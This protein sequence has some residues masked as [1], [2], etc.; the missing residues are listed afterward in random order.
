[1]AEAEKCQNRR[2]L[3]QTPSQDCQ[4]GNNFSLS[5][6]STTPNEKLLKLRYGTLPTPNLDKSAPPQFS[7]RIN[8]NSFC[9]IT[10]GD[11]LSAPHGPPTKSSHVLKPTP[12]PAAFPKPSELP[13][14]L[15]PASA[16]HLAELLSTPARQPRASPG[17]PEVSG[18]GPGRAPGD[19][20]PPPRGTL[21]HP[22][23]P[24]PAHLTPPR[25]LCAAGSD[26]P[27]SLPCRPKSSPGP[28]SETCSSSSSPHTWTQRRRRRLVRPAAPSGWKGGAGEGGGRTERKE[29]GWR[30]GR[31]GVEGSRW[32]RKERASRAGSGAGEGRRGLR[33]PPRGRPWR[34][35]PVGPPV[36]PARGSLPG[37]PPHSPLRPGGGEG[38]Q[39]GGRQPGGQGTRRRLRGPERAGLPWLLWGL[40][41][42][43]AADWPPSPPTCPGRHVGRK[44]RVT[45][46]PNGC[47]G[48]SGGGVGVGCPE[49]P[50]RREAGGG[51][52]RGRSGS[53][54]SATVAR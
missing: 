1:M 35:A 17:L 42:A 3:P 37:H 29:R 45:Q 40:A 6:Q 46:R 9:F 13:F 10:K 16:P 43:V 49:L 26:A 14:L 25:T 47:R 22:S 8:D 50:R 34:A 20:H 7:K 21:P 41:P 28:G 4:Q 15:H 48:G 32:I 30:W 27:S 54:R 12:S 39:P 52:R 18:A 44:R 24:L 53:S 5:F 31:G 19:P 33:R 51:G 36:L 23:G 2:H 11:I 38:A